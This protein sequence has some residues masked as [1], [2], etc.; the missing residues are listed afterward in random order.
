MDKA[1]RR[2]KVK[3]LVYE[4]GQRQMDTDN[5]TLLPPNLTA[6]ASQHHVIAYGYLRDNAGRLWLVVDACVRNQELYKPHTPSS[7]LFLTLTRHNRGNSTKHC[8]R[9]FLRPR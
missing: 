5:H 6:S 4:Q 1:G 2:R 3:A 7:N 9:V 8:R